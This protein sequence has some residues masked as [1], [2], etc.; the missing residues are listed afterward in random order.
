MIL[1]MISLLVS[2]IHNSTSPY[3]LYIHYVYCRDNVREC[4]YFHFLIS[5]FFSA[6]PQSLSEVPMRRMAT[7]QKEPLLQ[8]EDPSRHNKHINWVNQD[9]L[10]KQ[11]LNIK[12]LGM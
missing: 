1:Q 8:F 7:H 3:I 10:I 9:H 12:N 4:I 11:L 6:K 5:L 2:V